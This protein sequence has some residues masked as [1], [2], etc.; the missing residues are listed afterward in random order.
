MKEIKKTFIINKHKP[1]NL[2]GINKLQ[3]NIKDGIFGTFYIMLK[4]DHNSY[5]QYLIYL[6]IE[7]FQLLYF[8]F[9]YSVQKSWNND[10][11][12]NVVQSIFNKVDI[13]YYFSA[14]STSSLPYIVTFYSCFFILFVIL[15]NLIYIYYLYIK[16][17]F[18]GNWPLFTIKQLLKAFASFLFIPFLKLFFSI[19]SCDLINSVSVVS[20]AH[21]MT[22]FTDFYFLHM[23]VAIISIIFMLLIGS[24]YVSIY[25]E[26]LSSNNIMS[27]MNSNIEYTVFMSKIILVIL[28]TFMAKED[29]SIFLIVIQFLLASAVV[30]QIQSNKPYKNKIIQS[31]TM[32]CYSIWLWTSFVLLFSN[33]L[34]Y[35]ELSGA[36]YIWITGIPLVFVLVVFNQFSNNLDDI[37]DI[38]SIQAYESPEKVE[39]T[40]IYLLTLLENYHDKRENEVILKGFVRNHEDNC[41]LNDCPLKAI[42]RSMDNNAENN[43][44]NMFTQQFIIF[45]NRT[46]LNA[47]HKYQS[48]A[49]LRIAFALFLYLT[50][51]Q[52][53]K[54]KQELEFAEKC[55]PS[56]DQQFMIFRYKKLI[57]ED[58][59]MNQNQNE[60]LDI[61]SSI[62]Y[63][64]H[65]RQ[66]QSDILNVAKLFMEFWSILSSQNNNPDILKLNDLSLKINETI[67]NIHIHWKRMQ[68]YKPNHP[69]AIKVY[70]SFYIDL[71]N[72]KE[73][74]KEILSLSKETADK[75]FIDQDIGN[76]VDDDHSNGQCIITCSAE[77]DNFGSV[78]KVSANASKI[79]CYLPEDMINGKPIDDLFVD[80]YNNKLTTL[81]QDLSLNWGNERSR[82]EYLLYTKSR[83]HRTFPVYMKLLDPSKQIGDKIHFTIAIKPFEN[84]NEDLK[85]YARPCYV[86]FSSSLNISI[87]SESLIEFLSI[88][89]NSRLPEINHLINL[90]PELLKNF[91]KNDIDGYINNIT[92][93]K[94][95][96]TILY[97]FICENNNG[98]F[99]FEFYSIKNTEESYFD[100]KPFNVKISIDKV[101]IDAYIEKDELINKAED[102]S[103]TI[104]NKGYDKENDITKGLNDPAIKE[105][106]YVL[107]IEYY[108][109]S[110]VSKKFLQ[111]QNN[112][113]TQTPQYIIPS[114]TEKKFNRNMI[115]QGN[116]LNLSIEKMLRD[117]DNTPNMNLMNIIRDKNLFA[118]LFIWE[119][120]DPLRY[121]RRNNKQT[122]DISDMTLKKAQNKIIQERTD[123][124]TSMN[125]NKSLTDN[126]K[127]PSFANSEEDD[128]EVSELTSKSNTGDIIEEEAEDILKEEA[129]NGIKK[130]V[131]LS[132]IKSMKDYSKSIR[133][134]IL[135]NDNDPREELEEPKIKEFVSQVNLNNVDLSEGQS[136]NQSSNIMF[137]G[138]KEQTEKTVPA[139]EKLQWTSLIVILVIIAYSIIELV[140]NSQAKTR[141]KVNFNLTNYSYSLLNEV[142]WSSYLVRNL[143]L[144]TKNPSDTYVHLD[145]SSTSNVV[146]LLN[147]INNSTVTQDN[148]ISLISNNQIKLTLTQEH[149]NLYNTDSILIYES[150]TKTFKQQ[151]ISAVTQLRIVLVNINT[152]NISDTFTSYYLINT[153]NEFLISL[154]QNAAYFSHL[155]IENAEYFKYLFIYYYL[156]LILICIVFITLVYNIIDKVEK[157]RTKILFS[158]YE[159][160]TSYLN[161]LTEKCLKYVEKFEKTSE[162]N[163]SENQSETFL[164]V[165]DEASQMKVSKKKHLFKSKIKSNKLLL[166]KTI[167]IYLFILAFFTINFARNI[168]T[169]DKVVLL[170]NVFNYTS[171]AESQ[172]GFSFNLEREKIIDKQLKVLGNRVDIKLINDTIVDLYDINNNILV[173]QIE[174]KS[175]FSDNYLQSIRSIYHGDLCLLNK[176]TNCNQLIDKF[177]QYG[178]QIVTMKY[179]ENLHLIYNK[180]IKVNY[181]INANNALVSN[182]VVNT[183]DIYHHFI[184]PSSQVLVTQLL[185]EILNYLDNEMNFRL[186]VFLFFIVSYVLGYLI[187]WIPFQNNMKDEIFRT[188]KMLDILPSSI[189]DEIE[190]Y[191]NN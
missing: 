136:V 173:N 58:L 172:F 171:L 38:K 73:K 111:I 137:K 40:I 118:Q 133:C 17:I 163:N 117:Q 112:S 54:A 184:R 96:D 7:L 113:L 52:K 10:S 107:K 146:K 43:N 134:Y 85:E 26:A 92:T 176:P 79:F 150:S 156:L 99:D 93:H 175:I 170:S 69:K 97:D 57:I 174:K 28:F 169:Y 44:V 56:F 183:A 145:D 27:K 135:K 2:E 168:I 95:Y 104:K 114:N 53:V 139:L 25:Y 11:F 50:Q 5:A 189:L 83:Q 143:L 1:E 185:T 161:K 4:Q 70:A 108:L 68:H 35:S 18:P 20:V 94:I 127:N 152:Q 100:E 24:I 80:C 82:K 77:N 3:N 159:I 72:D 19:F 48:S 42:K 49:S 78:V 41:N 8:A 90:F 141:M 6:K 167:V 123:E 60:A 149:Q 186:I 132:K 65:F 154:Q 74:G 45:L 16:S 102:E 131:L 76:N 179:L 59:D 34:N 30:I 103:P 9:H 32:I 63:E 21:S 22:C 165:E 62:A 75:K 12:V 126:N 88:K 140:L 120:L 47:L 166:V 61:A 89:Y 125:L 147:L 105:S 91:D 116:K 64:S 86:I 178:L 98:L 81:M 187:V 15:F 142:V 182:D 106:Y 23:F 66:C 115:Q 138:P 129:E 71:L 157:E 29:N 158:F 36:I 164:D 13:I 37:L 87:F 190:S 130:D 124:N 101:D 39:R 33:I 121:N 148:L 67:K 188:Q 128:D 144:S 122:T 109:I 181:T 191:K 31:F 180:Y 153:F 55:C 14:S 51:K 84:L 151:F 155:L 110:R 46:Y 119:G 160:P 162:E 177:A